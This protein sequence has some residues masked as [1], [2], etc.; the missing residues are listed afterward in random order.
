MNEGS[1]FMKKF[2]CLFIA[3]L[4][5]A[6]VG[7]SPVQDEIGEARSPFSNLSVKNVDKI[8]VAYGINSYTMSDDE[9]N[10][11]VPLLND[12][13]IYEEDDSWKDNDG[14]GETEIEIHYQDTIEKARFL[15]SYVVLNGQGY[16]CEHQPC[17]VVSNVLY[18]ITH[19]EF[20]PSEKP[21]ENLSISNVESIGI[22]KNQN[23]YQL[24][25]DE[26]AALIEI[27]NTVNTYGKDPETDQYLGELQEHFTLKK[28][29]GSKF[30]VSFFYPNFKINGTHYIADE[31]QVRQGKELYERICQEQFPQ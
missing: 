24:N 23:E 16:R 17:I 10:S 20:Y 14:V 8:V 13:I 5:S 18:R 7:C 28:K 15:N 21:F 19:R 9:K 27:L 30:I 2:L 3:L 26:K 4:V 22:V 25:A 1:T 31:D 11:F 12:I 6:L 29:D